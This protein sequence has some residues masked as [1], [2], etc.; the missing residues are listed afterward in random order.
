[1]FDFSIEPFCGLVLKLIEND[2]AL[3]FWDGQRWE[4]VAFVSLFGISD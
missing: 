3:K 2:R 1:V 4:K